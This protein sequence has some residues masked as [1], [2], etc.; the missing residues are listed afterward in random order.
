[1]IRFLSSFTCFSKSS[2]AFCFR[3]CF[4]LRNPVKNSLKKHV[5]KYID[6]EVRITFQLTKIEWKWMFFHYLLTFY[7]SDRKLIRFSSFYFLS[8]CPFW[9]D[10]MQNVV[11]SLRFNS[12]L[13]TFVSI[14]V[15]KCKHEDLIV[16]MWAVAWRSI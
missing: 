2:L 1:M 4:R 7:S 12:N 9:F 15:G 13:N 3:S 10:F 16:S 14:V 11:E 6:F 8:A 5:N